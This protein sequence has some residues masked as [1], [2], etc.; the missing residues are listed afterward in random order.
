VRFEN[1]AQN[2]TKQSYVLSE[3]KR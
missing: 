2:T 1:K 3:L